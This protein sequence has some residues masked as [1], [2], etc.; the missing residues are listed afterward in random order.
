MPHNE[1]NSEK[2]NLDLFYVFFS[3]S[4]FGFFI[5]ENVGYNSTNI[6]CIS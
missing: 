2:K 4:D 3:P 1:G 6:I 5:K